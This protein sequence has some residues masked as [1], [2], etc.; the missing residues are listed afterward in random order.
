MIFSK[1]FV[2]KK[3]KMLSNKV[4]NLLKNSKMFIATAESCTGGY[5]AKSITAVPGASNTF[6]YGIVSYSN[7]AKVNLLKVKEESLILYTAVSP[8]VAREMASGVRKISGASVGVSTTGYA[9]GGKT[10]PDKAGTVYICVS[11]CN[12]D[13]TVCKKYF[14][15]DREMVRLCA[16]RDALKHTIDVITKTEKLKNVQSKSSL[17][18]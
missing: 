18:K 4:V 10:P 17:R 7:A 12:Y 5:I 15:D 9:G 13:L 8:T 3:I 16:T 2:R 11:C 6:G 14:Y 1:F